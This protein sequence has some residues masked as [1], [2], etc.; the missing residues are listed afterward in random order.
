MSFHFVEKLCRP[1]QFLQ[2]ENNERIETKALGKGKKG[3]IGE[4]MKQLQFGLPQFG[5]CFFNYLKRN[6]RLPN[7]F[8]L[9]EDLMA[10]DIFIHKTAIF[11]PCSRKGTML[12]LQ[13]ANSYYGNPCFDVVSY[14]ENGETSLA[15]HLNLFFNI[16]QN[17]VIS[18]S[19][20][21]FTMTVSANT[22]DWVAHQK[23][24]KERNEFVRA[25]CELWHENH[26]HQRDH[27]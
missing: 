6:Q 1:E 15:V 10:Q 25:L 9:L 23:T 5:E 8:Q 18:S 12:V 26:C 11:E 3:K 13:A 7:R 19:M 2:Q 17:V 20:V 24:A 4:I 27:C 14:I 22:A 16:S 21:F